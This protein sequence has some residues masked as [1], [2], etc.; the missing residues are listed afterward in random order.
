MALFHRPKTP[1][2]E[3]LNTKMPIPDDNPKTPTPKLPLMWKI[4]KVKRITLEKNKVQCSGVFS[5]QLHRRCLSHGPLTMAI[6]LVSN[7]I[8]VFGVFS[9]LTTVCQ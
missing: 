4:E 5:A 1:S 6:T 8:L 9:R 3:N 7:F 2:T